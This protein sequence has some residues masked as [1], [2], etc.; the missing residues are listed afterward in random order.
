MT[1]TTY[2]YEYCCKSNLILL[3]VMFAPFPSVYSFIS[4]IDIQKLIIVTNTPSS[5]FLGMGGF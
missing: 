5:L 4:N 1:I 3:L 2:L